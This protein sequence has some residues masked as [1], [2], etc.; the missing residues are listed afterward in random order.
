M[1]SSV[2]LLVARRAVSDGDDDTDDDL[3]IGVGIL[4]AD[5]SELA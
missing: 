5:K 1:V 2:S 4:L 3:V